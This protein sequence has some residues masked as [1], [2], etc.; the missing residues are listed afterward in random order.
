MRYVVTNPYEILNFYSELNEKNKNKKTYDTTPI[1]N[2][3]TGKG[4]EKDIKNYVIG[5]N[6]DKF[7][8][9]KGE[10][11]VNYIVKDDNILIDS[12]ESVK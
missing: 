11:I 9:K 8:K 5:S 10:F 1:F 2:Y 6:F 12:Y 4:K 3:L 7:A